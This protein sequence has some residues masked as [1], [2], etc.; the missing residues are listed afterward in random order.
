MHVACGSNR[1]YTGSTP[2]L[3]V[4]VAEP[5]SHRTQGRRPTATSILT[6]PSIPLLLT[7]HPTARPSAQAINSPPTPQTPAQA[8]SS[9]HKRRPLALPHRQFAPRPTGPASRGRPPHPPPT[10]P[11][12]S[13]VPSRPRCPS[14]RPIAPLG[15]PPAHPPTHQ[16][17]PVSSSTPSSVTVELATKRARTRSPK[18]TCSGGQTAVKRRP[19][20]SQ[21]VHQL[22]KLKL[23]LGGYSV[24]HVVG[25]RGLAAAPSGKGPARPEI[26]S[27]HIGS[28]V[29]R[30]Q[31]GDSEATTAPNH[32]VLGLELASVLCCALCCA[33][34]LSRLPAAR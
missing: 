12:P 5:T 30:T 18:S 11:P 33:I 26:P 3:H 15:Y 27:P 9:Q 25:R 8:R 29:L 24:W 21:T 2:V 23:P 32:R 6:I 16:L 4:T 34:A 31:S 14:P 20:S 7:C 13:P 28:A 22:W 19:G 17:A 10:D 1:Q